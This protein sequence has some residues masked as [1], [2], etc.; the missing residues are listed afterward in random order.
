MIY[1]SNQVAE[2]IGENILIFKVWKD[3]DNFVTDYPD[4]FYIEKL[5]KLIDRLESNNVFLY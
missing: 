1:N 4:F 2:S 3:T 5:K